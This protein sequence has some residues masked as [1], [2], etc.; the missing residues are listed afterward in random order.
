[1][2]LQEPTLRVIGNERV[3]ALGDVSGTEASYEDLGTSN[4]PQATSLPATAQVAFQ[5]ADYVAWNLWA[6]M[7]GRSLLPFKYQ[8]LGSMMSLGSLNAAVALPVPVPLP[9][10][11]AVLG[12]PL[13][14]LLDFAGVKLDGD[15]VTLEGPLAMAMRRAAYLYRQPTNEQRLSVASG[16]LQQ[17]LTTASGLA[18]GGGTSGQ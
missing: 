9:I 14:P 15:E 10:K 7:N 13:A 17:A 12:S 5:Q 16:W 2:C 6:S 3:F 8:H 1:M 11:S 18:R 4:Q